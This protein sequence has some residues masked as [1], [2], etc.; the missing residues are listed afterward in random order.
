MA[1]LSLKKTFIE[2]AATPYRKRKKILDLAALENKI[3]RKY[4][5]IALVFLI[6]FLLNKRYFVFLIIT[7]FSTVFSY[8]NSK[9]NRTPIDF[10]MALFLGL[11]ITRYYSLVFTFVFFVIS[12]IIPALLGGDSLDGP[13]LVF[14]SWYFIVNSMVYLFPYM[15]MARLGPL[16]VI[17]EA[18]GSIFIN[19]YVGGIPVFV[20]AWVSLI[21]VSVRIIYFL[22]LGKIIEAFFY[23]I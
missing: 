12:D 10:K 21:N 1:N 4:L 8:Y 6:L 11:F 17:V 2:K 14:I 3:N 7:G 20:S 18:V 22:T 9:F 16:L 13:S 23:L 5:I 15:P 19:S